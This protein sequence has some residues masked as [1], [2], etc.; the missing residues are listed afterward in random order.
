M[1]VGKGGLRG[2]MGSKGETGSD[3]LQGVPGDNIECIIGERTE[4]LIGM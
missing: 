2:D 4:N 3:G 1:Y